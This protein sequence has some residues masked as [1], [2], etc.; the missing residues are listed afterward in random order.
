M[1]FPLMYCSTM[2]LGPCFFM[3]AHCC[4]IGKIPGACSWAHLILKIAKLIVSTRKGA[5]KITGL[6]KAYFSGESWG[7]LLRFSFP[8]SLFF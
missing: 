1:Y 8:Q 2:R 4:I 3:Y 5:K 7:D 6:Q